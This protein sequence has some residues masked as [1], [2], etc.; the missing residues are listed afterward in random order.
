[1]ANTNPHP[2]LA[3]KPAPPNDYEQALA[4]AMEAVGMAVTAKLQQRDDHFRFQEVGR[5]AKIG[6]ALGRQKARA[7]ATVDGYVAPERR[8]QFACNVPDGGGIGRYYGG[9]GQ[10]GLGGVDPLDEP[11]PLGNYGGPIGGPGIINPNP[12]PRV[13]GDDG[14]PMAAFREVFDRIQS[15][16]EDKSDSRDRLDRLEEL[17]K[18]K[19]LLADKDLDAD[20]REILEARRTQVV[21][22]LK[23][24]NEPDA[25]EPDAADVGELAVRCL[26]PQCGNAHDA[27]WVTPA[28]EPLRCDVCNG[29]M[30][31]APA[32]TVGMG[33][34]L[35]EAD[36]A[37]PEAI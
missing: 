17:R 23:E 2:R 28:G 30:M 32:R 8:A 31:F 9:M 26:N 36:V 12:F 33:A 4:A 6:E 25:E 3:L 18:L 1:M 5:L 21:E 11:L 16:N 13:G 15:M 10:G 37:V 14:N 7:A 20:E 35:A 34:D 24:A 27:D 19:K 29:P 22:D